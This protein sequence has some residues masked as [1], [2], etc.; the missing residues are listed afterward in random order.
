MKFGITK[1]LVIPLAIITILVLGICAISFFT[2][3]SIKGSISENQ[4]ISKKTKTF[5]NLQAFLGKMLMPLEDYFITGS[6]IYRE[7][8]TNLLLVVNSTLAELKNFK[9]VNER[10]EALLREIEADFIL[11][12][13]TGYTLF[14]INDPSKD[15]RAVELLDDIKQGKIDLVISYKI[16]RLTRSPRDFYQLIQ[17]S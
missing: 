13:Q 4:V 17:T 12:E 3:N 6:A 7:N 8:F 2:L 1:K 15:Q 11:I 5:T 14:S 10:E 9:A 16:D